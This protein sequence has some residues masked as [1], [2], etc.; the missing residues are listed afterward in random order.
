[1]RNFMKM[2]EFHENHEILVE[3]HFFSKIAPGGSGTSPSA[4]IPLAPARSGKENPI[5]F[6]KNSFMNKNDHANENVTCKK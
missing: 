4:K 1:M 3:F 2:L 5:V 6:T